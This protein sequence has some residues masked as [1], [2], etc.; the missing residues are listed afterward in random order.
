MYCEHDN[1][2]LVLALLVK[3][4]CIYNEQNAMKRVDCVRWHVL[5][6]FCPWCWP[7]IGPRSNMA[8]IISY[9]VGLRSLW[10]TN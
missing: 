7:T 6:L 10:T 4:V 3:T 5:D 9:R 1:V 2:F 8:T